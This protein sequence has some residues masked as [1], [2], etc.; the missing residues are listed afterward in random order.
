[1]DD[2]AAAQF[3]KL[4]AVRPIAERA[5]AAIWL[6]EGAAGAQFARKTMAVP[7][8]ALRARGLFMQRLQALAHLHHPNLASVPAGRVQKRREC[9]VYT[10]YAPRGSLYDAVAVPGKRLWTLPLP[11]LDALRLTQAI[12]EGVQALH[13]AGLVHGGL[14]LS[15]VLLATE[16]DGAWRPKV[17]DALLHEGFA[18]GP[19]RAGTLR[20]T[21]LADPW[22]YLAPEQYA[23]R[24]DLASDQYALAV[25]AFVLLTGETPYTLDAIAHLQARDV[26]PYQK[27]STVNPILPLGMDAVLWRGLSRA[28]KARYPSARAFAA[29][30]GA[31]LGDHDAPRAVS[32]APGSIPIPRAAMP[33]PPVAQSHEEMSMPLPLAVR[34]ETGS[35]P[36]PG[37]PDLPANYSWVP[38]VVSTYRRSDVPLPSRKATT[39]RNVVPTGAIVA[40]TLL[41]ALLAVLLA[42]MLLHH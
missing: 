41:L 15:N 3:A 20:P 22:L 30:L 37:L 33:P 19:L 16:A 10:E 38:D 34:D 28:P 26:S 27:A 32:L 11:P 35:I 8:F 39:R 21:D 12:A 18:G 23:G 25:I 13:G 1:M 2:L 24:P 9:I 40:V 42:V 14:K 7:L 17:T 5:D 31:A 29:A 36:V 4:R 6:M